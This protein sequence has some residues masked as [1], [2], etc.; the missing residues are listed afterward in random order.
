MRIN[1]PVPR[2]VPGM[3]NVRLERG[4][5]QGRRAGRRAGADGPVA[6]R[7]RR[8]PDRAGRAHRP[9]GRRVSRRSRKFVRALGHHFMVGSMAG[10]VPRVTTRPWRLLRA[11]PEERP[12]PPLLGDPRGPADRDRDLEAH[13]P[14]PCATGAYGLGRS[15]SPLRQRRAID[16]SPT[17][18]PTV[19]AVLER[20]HGDQRAQI[21][22]SI[23][24]TTSPS[25]RTPPSRSGEGSPSSPRART[26]PAWLA[27]VRR[28][29]RKRRADQARHHR[30]P[31]VL[32]TAAPSRS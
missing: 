22:I 2:R 11:A 5:H 9:R 6:A 19:I 14:A 8:P 20:I 21:G 26:P 30:S 3:Q 28:G 32:A 29:P 23:A 25:T 27:A 17:T 31:S 18:A 1:N 16:L 15:V 13:R 7:P 24:P 4:L 10:S 12:Q